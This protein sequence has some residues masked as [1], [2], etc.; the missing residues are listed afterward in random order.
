[1]C[2]VLNGNRASSGC[3]VLLYFVLLCVVF[4]RGMDAEAAPFRGRVVDS[5]TGNPLE[6][7]QVF[8]RDLNI[9]T[10]TNRNGEFAIR[11]N[12][13]GTHR[14]MVTYVGYESYDAQLQFPID[15]LYLVRLRAT[16]LA[17]DEVVVTAR[18]VQ[19]SG[20]A[21]QINQ[22]ALEHTQPSSLADVMQF[23]P[24]QLATDGHLD[25]VKQATLRQV[26]ADDNT[27]LGT[28]VVVNGV[29]MSNN[30]NLNYISADQKVRERTTVNS[31]L[32][33]RMLSTDHYERVDLL[34][35][36]ASARYGD[37]SSG[38][39][40]LR[41]KQGITPWQLRAK[42]D[43]LAGL[44]Y[45]GKGVSL[46]LGT[47][48]LGGEYTYATPDE[49]EQLERYSRYSAQANW[50]GRT[51]VADLPLS[52]GLRAHYVGTLQTE[53][54]DPDLTLRTDKYLA[55][56]S[57]YQ[58][59][60]DADLAVEQPWLASVHL[61]ASYDY[62]EDVVRRIRN[63]SV[64]AGQGLPISDKEGEYEGIYLPF[65]YI[66][67]Y[68]LVNKP[69]QGYGLLELREHWQFWH[70]THALNA[71]LETRWEGNIGRGYTYD[72][73][74]P[75]APGSPTSSRPRRYSDVPFYIPLS[76]Y[77]EDKLTISGLWG[78]VEF[79]AG[80]RAG[81]LRGATKGYPGLQKAQT[82]PRINA[83]YAFPSFYIAK[84]P[85]QVALRL[86]WGKQT[87]WPT[88]DHLA[89]TKSYFDLQ[90][91]NYYSLTEEWRLLWLTTFIEDARNLD[92]LPASYNKWEGGLD[93]NLGS[94]RAEVTLFYE[95]MRNGFTYATHYLPYEYNVY[96]VPGAPS[97]KP[98]IQTLTPR[99]EYALKSL[100][101]P[102]NSLST[103]K[104]GIEFRL[105]LPKWELLGTSADISGAYFH[106]TYDISLPEEYRPSIKLEGKEY[107]Y[108]GIYAWSNGRSYERLSSMA[109]FYTHLPRL[110]LLFT[111]QVQCVWFTQS[112]SLPFDG[113]PL[114]WRD[115][116]GEV[117][118]FTDEDAKDPKRIFLVRQFNKEYFEVDRTPFALS[119]NLKVT[120]EI[121]KHVRLAFF[122]NRIWCYL[123]DYRGKF[124][125]LITRDYTPYFGT[126]LR[127]SL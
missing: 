86:G 66:S 71:G 81:W 15:T 41:A 82:D 119:L 35:G 88:L 26:G 113:R 43:P 68:S 97:G 28:A 7:A 127:I 101:K 123:P 23:L 105:Q 46:P 1:M 12:F 114:Y 126:E 14:L 56:Y 74:R 117:K 111:T 37:L 96:S 47:L 107:P 57:R 33:L 63:I 3:R 61:T 2:G 64:H 50:T 54:T 58:L 84:L 13:S 52:L 93:L 70:M 51:H 94:A 4:G 62:T 89:P 36:I 108:V 69:L 76:A 24:G 65:E 125:R 118:P 100:G 120:K 116:N 115:I 31:G 59:S 20:T 42:V 5:Q 98:D 29:P 124:H 10:L 91:L 11:G 92:L 38:A 45:L 79:V 73:E 48:H 103:L 16:S 32:D 25:Q 87:K 106:T 53:R 27:S 75:P 67:H 8:L 77:I 104:R 110:R 83:Y 78:E 90:S 17:L 112:K 44:V 99:K 40:L 19:K 102:S 18:A 122:A 55:Y 80:L 21:L 109:R 22:S 49:R 6:S 72:L 121:G 34:R 95:S 30:A 9:G 39:F 85:I 60:G